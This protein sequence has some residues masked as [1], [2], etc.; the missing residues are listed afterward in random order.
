M[1]FIF[2]FIFIAATLFI[3]SCST[4]SFTKDIEERNTRDGQKYGIVAYNDQGLKELVTG[5]RDEAIARAQEHCT[6][7][8]TVKIVKEENKNLVDIDPSYKNSIAR[9]LNSHPRLVHYECWEKEL[10]E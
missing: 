2:T 4:H 7:A 6:P 10:I 9:G 5:R 1:K 8:L 3:Q